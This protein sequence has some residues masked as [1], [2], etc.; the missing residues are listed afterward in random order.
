MNVSFRPTSL[1][2]LR[3]TSLQAGG[4]YREPF[5]AA[6]PFTIGTGRGLPFPGSD[7]A[8]VYFTDSGDQNQ[9]VNFTDADG[10]VWATTSEVAA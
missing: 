9:L 4:A 7:R 3:I 8:Y 1:G 10:R 6:P 2:N 5:V